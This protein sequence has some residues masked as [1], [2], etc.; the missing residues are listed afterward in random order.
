MFYT[1]SPGSYVALDFHKACLSWESN[2][3]HRCSQLTSTP[4]QNPEPTWTPTKYLSTDIVPRPI[5][6]SC[7]R[8][9]Q[10]MWSP[11]EYL[12]R[13]M[14]IPQSLS[15]P[16]HLRRQTSRLLRTL[17]TIA[18]PARFISNCRRESLKYFQ[19]LTVSLNTTLSWVMVDGG[20]V[21]CPPAT[22]TNLALH[23]KSSILTSK[24]IWQFTRWYPIGTISPI[25]NFLKVGITSFVSLVIEY[26]QWVLPLFLS[27]AYACATYMGTSTPNLCVFLR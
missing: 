9:S 13:M 3:G 26:A 25:Y 24:I 20:Y 18:V 17:P 5:I 27:R 10:P 8:Q 22:T 14:G 11:T 16:K 6:I 15:V 21:T 1:L 2:Q 23:R 4:T 7:R 19:L 12:Q